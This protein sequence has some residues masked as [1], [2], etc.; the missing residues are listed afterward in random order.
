MNRLGIVVLL[1]IG[2]SSCVAG[3]KV[4]PVNEV[5]QA[6]H[7]PLKTKGYPPQPP[8]KAG[9]TTTA[10]TVKGSRIM[11][12]K[13]GGPAAPFFIK[14][15][16][17]SPTQIGST[18]L[19]PLDNTN[20]AI[21]QRDLPQLRS[22]GANAVR[23]Y[24]AGLYQYGSGNSGD[25]YATPIDKWLKAAWGG[26]T[27]PIYTIVEINFAAGILSP[28]SSGAITSVANQYYVLARAVGCDPDVMGISIGGEWNGSYVTNPATWTGLN[29]IINGAYQGLK[30]VGAKKIIMTSLV[31]DL[32][33]PLSNSAM[34][35][36]EQNGFP[37][38]G[39]A[40]SS[41][42]R[43]LGP[44][45]SGSPTP[46]DPGIQFVWGYDVYSSFSTFTQSAQSVLAH[47]HVKR[48]VVM[49]EWGESV[50]YHPYPSPFPA[51]PK[52]GTSP[53]PMPSAWVVEEWPSPAASPAPQFSAALAYLD[54]KANQLYAQYTNPGS[55]RLSGG[56]YFEWSDEWW[57]GRKTAKGRGCSHIAGNGAPAVLTPSG[58][59]SGFWDNGWFGLNSVAL[60]ASSSS[61]SSSS[62]PDVL[63]P[64]ATY[65][66]L[67]ND[68]SG[69]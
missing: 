69:Q 16:D 30:S 15:V 37:V 9:S 4:L 61:C 58:W 10:W 56:F 5:A 57:A 63:T 18:Y 31:N 20:S 40:A 23:V 43:A 28:A 26:G 33:T 64:R 65:A 14:G 42:S 29:Q 32:G 39:Y 60:P 38:G 19:E 6:K 27:E 67:Q 49:G 44:R 25:W 34:W 12:S 22:L 13:N 21:W 54:K 24:N 53:S 47:F 2:L 45:A 55:A 46:N 11:L 50:G 35:N 7:G 8:C 68:W 59:P 51:N 62:A 41:S 1:L 3:T 66:H 52:Y 17:Y 48:P 36:G